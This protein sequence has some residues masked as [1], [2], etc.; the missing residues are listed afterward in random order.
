MVV[1]LDLSLRIP[2]LARKS[3]PFQDVTFIHGDANDL[4]LFSDGSFNY[5]T[6]LMLMHQLPSSQQT[7]I[8]KEALRVASRGIIIDSVA[9]LPR[10]AGGIGIRIVERIFGHDHNQHFKDFVAKGGIKGIWE[11]M[12]GTN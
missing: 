11:N 2:D 8:L 1:G 5:A 7:L 9:P 3:N 12:R 6:M 10:N 4:A